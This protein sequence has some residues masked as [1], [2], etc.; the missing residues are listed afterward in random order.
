MTI[1]ELID[2]YFRTVGQNETTLVST[3]DDPPKHRLGVTKDALGTSGGRGLGCLSFNVVS[4]PSEDEHVL[5]QGKRTDDGGG[6]F[7]IGLKE[8]NSPS[9]D[10]AMKDALIVT[11]ERGF[12]FRLPI[13][14][15]N[16]TGGQVSEQFNSTMK[17]PNGY[18]WFTMQGD[19]NLVCYKNRIKYDYTTG[20]PYWSTGTVVH[21]EK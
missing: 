8:P 12:E 20:V 11:N 17:H 21:E 18:I 15:P 19:G 13:S 1:A 6:E 7:Y 9:K 14:A 5:V 10:E 2:G 4:G 16:L 3:V